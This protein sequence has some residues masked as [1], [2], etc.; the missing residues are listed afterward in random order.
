M[1][2]P[3]KDTKFSQSL[4]GKE[5]VGSPEVVGTRPNQ[6]VQ[7]LSNMLPSSVQ[8]E[9]TPLRMGRDEI[10]SGTHQNLKQ[11]YNPL[12][13]GQAFGGAR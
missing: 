6:Y 7:R 9:Q 4:K 12:F 10:P 2:P 1:A 13:E 5:I 3:K 11:M 8:S